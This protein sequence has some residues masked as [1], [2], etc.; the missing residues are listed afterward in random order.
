MSGKVSVTG[1]PI[2]QFDSVASAQ[3]KDISNFQGVQPASFWSGYQF[4]FAK[5]T[6]STNFLDATFPGNWVNMK[7]AGIHR[8]AYH[9]F[10][11]A[12]DP[13][14][15]AKFFVSYVEKQG[16]EPGD[17][18]VADVEITSGGKIS[19]MFKKTRNNLTQ[20]A[21]STGTVNV[22]AKA[23]LDEVVK[24]VGTKFPVLVYTDLSVGSQLTSCTGYPLWIAF[25]SSSAPSNVSPWKNWTFWQ[26]GQTTID[27]DAYN[28]TAADLQAFIDK[29]ALD[30]PP[31]T[32]PYRHHLSHDTT[33]ANL[34]ASRNTKVSTFLSRQ[35]QY[36]TSTDAAESVWRTG[37]VYYTSNP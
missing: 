36:Y 24:L 27:R 4:G 29:Y 23:F 22:T 8:G 19:R 30:P 13:I 7:R 17:M 35:A 16:L 31:P 33:V 20:R 6:E 9:F 37:S 28:G 15:Q 10:H 2:A 14:A 11:P 34:A 25:P 32:G 21:V 1:V 18:L 12:V 5:A 26:W 3:G